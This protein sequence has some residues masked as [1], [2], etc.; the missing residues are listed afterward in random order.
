MGFL[1]LSHLSNPLHLNKYSNACFRYL[2][3][4]GATTKKRG[5]AAQ[6]WTGPRLKLLRFAFGVA[7]WFAPQTLRTKGSTPV[8]RVHPMHQNK[9]KG[10]G[11]KTYR[12]C[13]NITLPF[14]TKGAPQDRPTHCAWSSA[15]RAGL[16]A[17]APSVSRSWPA[18]TR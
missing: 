2:C 14:T 6:S 15:P 17:G 11:P 3:S 1:T 12:A 4:S 9:L 13:L 16:P 18:A 8:A 10:W 5:Q 7:R